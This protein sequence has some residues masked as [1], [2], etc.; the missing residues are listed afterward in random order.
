MKNAAKFAVGT[1]VAMLCSCGTQEPPASTA[2]A[3][4]HEP[5]PTLAATPPPAPDFTVFGVVKLGEPLK[6]PVCNDYVPKVTCIQTW[7]PA[8][9]SKRSVYIPSLAESDRYSMVVDVIV[10][11]GNAE[12]AWVESLAH[13]GADTAMLDDLARKYGRPADHGRL[14]DSLVDWASWEFSGLHV[15]WYG[16]SAEVSHGTA[17]LETDRGRAFSREQAAQKEAATPQ[18]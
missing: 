8:G 10:L 18:L 12:G 7:R 9:D 2:L 14:K 4:Q 11:D 5:Q 6:L 1:S 15:S 17:I 3:E 13:F 16:R